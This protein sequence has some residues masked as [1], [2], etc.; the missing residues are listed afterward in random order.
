M[1]TTN[2]TIQ[3]GIRET[4]TFQYQIYIPTYSQ[5]RLQIIITSP[6]VSSS[7]SVNILS[8]NII[9]AGINVGSFMSE[10]ALGNKY[11]WTYSSSVSGSSYKDTAYLDLGV[12]S[13]TGMKNSVFFQ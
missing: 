3:S 1:S 12:V 10:Y 13:N 9:S 5:G 4:V 2:S 11:Q 6:S 8:A 7:V